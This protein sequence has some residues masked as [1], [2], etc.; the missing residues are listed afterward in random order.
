MIFAALYMKSAITWY[1]HRSYNA[2][3]IA[4]LSLIFG[5]VPSIRGQFW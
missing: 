1:Q 5:W 3:I 2:A 4:E